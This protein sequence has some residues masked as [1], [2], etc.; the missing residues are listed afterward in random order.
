MGALNCPKTDF[1]IVVRLFC[2]AVLSSLILIANPGFFNHDELQ[3]ADY[4]LRYGFTDYFRQY[5]TLQRSEVFGSPV[6]PVSFLV[7]GVVSRFTFAYPF[8]VHLFDVLMHGAIASIAFVAARSIHGD[9]QFALAG[10]MIF[11]I[12]PLVTFSVGWAAALMD[13]LY[14]L[15]GLIAFVATHKYVTQQSGWNA[16]LAVLVASTLA[17]LSKETALILPGTM[18]IYVIFFRQMVKSG[19]FWAALLTWSAPPLFFLLYWAPALI[20]SLSVKVEGSYAPSTVSALENILIYTTYPFLTSL[21]DA[22]NWGLQTLASRWLA[23]AAHLTILMLLWHAF[24]YR[25][26][27]AYLI[28]YVLFLAPVLPISSQGAHYLYGSGIALSFAFAALMTLEWKRGPKMLV[29]FPVIFLAISIYHAWQNQLHIYSIGSCM[30]R[31]MNSL[32]SAY[33]ASGG[34][35]EMAVLVRPGAPGHVLHRFMTGRAHIGA[36]FPVRFQILEGQKSAEA[37]YIFNADCII[38]GE[39]L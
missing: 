38:Y 12:S 35:S 14:V 39:P 15:F 6:R 1:P 10:A 22:N 32:E 17:V 26:A 30:N 4:I 18:I 21:S 27:L 19:R 16:L 24:S 3:R 20:S 36:H 7:Q 37:A 34:P 9:R 8:V 28:G 13:R 33:L 11:L 25:A 31:A 2:F 5:V 23:G 29:A